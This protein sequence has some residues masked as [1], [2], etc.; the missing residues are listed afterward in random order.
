MRDPTHARSCRCARCGTPD[1]GPVAVLLT[2]REREVASLVYEDRTDR[3][4]ARELGVAISTVRAFIG[5]ISVKIRADA[6]VMRRRRAIVEWVR[7]S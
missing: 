4:I 7:S 2:P 1:I 6:G 3:E 5:N